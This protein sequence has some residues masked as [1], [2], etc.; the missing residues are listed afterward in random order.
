MTNI[1]MDGQHNL[2]MPE[3]LFLFTNYYYYWYYYYYYYYD[4]K[5]KGKIQTE[6]H[7]AR[8]SCVIYIYKILVGKFKGKR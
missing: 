3:L 7:V 5:K 2:T 4:D 6:G 1:G 8:M